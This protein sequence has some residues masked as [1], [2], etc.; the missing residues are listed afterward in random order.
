MKTEKQHQKQMI[1]S[2][3]SLELLAATA[4]DMKTPLVLI[5]GLSER[6]LNSDLS[7]EQRRQYLERIQ[8]SSERLL[9]LTETLSGAPTSARD[10]KPELV[11]VNVGVI[12]EA[13]MDELALHA[14]HRHIKLCLRGSS[15]QVVLTNKAA[16]YR[17]VSNLVDNAIKYS[18]PNS[19]VQL[20]STR[21]GND[22]NIT[23]RDNGP[24]VRKD[25]LNG[26]FSLFAR[27]MEP[28]TV[29]PGSSG[30]G[31]FISQQLAYSIDGTL[32]VTPL[33]SGSSF[34]LTVPIVRQLQLFPAAEQEPVQEQQT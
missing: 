11:A 32:S 30:L 34:S 2:R 28:T 9:Q 15:Q 31:L 27:A 19:E 14:E 18:K 6:L 16:L 13:V 12:L 23:V 5:S 4:H 29:L 17:I 25:H 22:V 8:I 7:A 1:N 26:I 21:R 3:S 24:G 10:R 20:R 33:A